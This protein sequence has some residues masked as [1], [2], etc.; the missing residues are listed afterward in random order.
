VRKQLDTDVE[1]QIGIPFVPVLLV[2]KTPVPIFRKYR[3][4]TLNGPFSP[5]LSKHDISDNGHV[6]FEFPAVVGNK[7]KSR[8]G[9]NQPLAGIK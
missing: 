2:L 3:F 1:A 5:K 4:G 6:Y 8:T 7:C 9:I